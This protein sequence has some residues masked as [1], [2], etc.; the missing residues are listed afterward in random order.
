MLAQGW[1][2]GQLARR[3]GLESMLTSAAIN[4]RVQQQAMRSRALSSLS[5]PNLSGKCAPLFVG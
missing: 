5:G 4:F 2:E 3:L 1:P